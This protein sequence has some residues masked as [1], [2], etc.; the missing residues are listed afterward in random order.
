MISRGVKDQML[1]FEFFQ[2]SLMILGLM[3]LPVRVIER[4]EVRMESL[5]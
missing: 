5:S 4:G 1:S 3:T 2:M